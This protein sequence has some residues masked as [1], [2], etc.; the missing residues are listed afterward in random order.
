MSDD[1]EGERGDEGEGEGTFEAE[2]NSDGNHLNPESE[3]DPED[4][5]LPNCPRC[6][7]PVARTT[8]IGPTDAV[9]GPC[10]CRVAPGFSK[11]GQSDTRDE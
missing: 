8:M 2:S 3:L 5:P 11:R 4:T 1:A 6:T 9:A 10:G 7:R